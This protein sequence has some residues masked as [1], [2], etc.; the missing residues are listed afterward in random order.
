MNVQPLKRGRGR[1]RTGGRRDDVLA[2]A[3]ELFAERGFHGASIPEIAARAKIAPGTIYRHFASKEAL[4]NELYQRSK[5]ALAEAL[6]GGEPGADLRLQFGHLWWRLVAFVRAQPLAF[7]FL[8]LHHH[9]AYLDAD[10]RAMELRVLAPIAAMVELGRAQRVLK[11]VSAE[12]LIVTVWG[13]F[14]GMIRAS[15]LGYYPLTDPIC[16][17]VESTCWDAIC[18]H[19]PAFFG[20]RT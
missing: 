7:S 6:L 3:L 19:E 4:V 1:P 2:A 14:C 8:E 5:R 17:Q 16:T 12:A 15:R 11:P 18:N 20:D 10:S 13:A 9:G